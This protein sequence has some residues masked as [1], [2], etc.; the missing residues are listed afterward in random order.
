MSTGQLLAGYDRVLERRRPVALARHFREV[1]VLSIAQLAARLGRSPAT[2]KTYFS[3]PSDDNNRPA[4]NPQGDSSGRLVVMH[5][6]RS[7]S[8]S[9]GS[10][11]RRHEAGVPDCPIC[12][13]SSQATS[14]EVAAP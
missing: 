9:L 1:E 14:G 13:F 6:R 8:R 5:G 4:D 11:R 12:P 3:D 7:A 10:L 2:I